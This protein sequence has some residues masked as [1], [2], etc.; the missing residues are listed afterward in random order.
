MN[1]VGPYVAHVLQIHEKS[2]T[3]LLKSPRG[4][5]THNF[6]NVRRFFAIKVV[7][8]KSLCLGLIEDI[9]YTR[10]AQNQIYITI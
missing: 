5:I 1:N 4:V 2:I 3:Y 10:S 8:E 7:T 9:A 6:Q